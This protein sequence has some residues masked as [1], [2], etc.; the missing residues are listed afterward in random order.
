M[1]ARLDPSDLLL[2]MGAITHPGHKSLSWLNS[3]DKNRIVHQ[4]HTEMINVSGLN[5]AE[6]DDSEPCTS[7]ETSI[8]IFRR[9]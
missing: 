7:K 4:L 9:R 8:Y 2:C 6:E 3:A 5:L 1:L